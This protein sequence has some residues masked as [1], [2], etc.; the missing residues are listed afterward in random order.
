MPINGMD[1]ANLFDEFCDI[2]CSLRNI[3]IDSSDVV[4]ITLFTKI[5]FYTGPD[6]IR[7][8]L[9]KNSIFLLHALFLIFKNAD[10]Y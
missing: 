8:I 2:N 6:N 3:D 10:K 9:Y 4:Y 7:Q 1:I 5:L